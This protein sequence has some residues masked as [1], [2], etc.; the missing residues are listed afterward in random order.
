[1][2]GSSP[3]EYTPHS[4]TKRVVTLYAAVLVGLLGLMAYYAFTI[5]T[6]RNDW[7]ALATR[8][9]AWGGNAGSLPLLFVAY[10]CGSLLSMPGLVM[11]TILVTCLGP[12]EGML[13]AMTGTAASSCTVHLLASKLGRAVITELY[14]AR[15]SQVE[16]LLKGPPFLRVLQM[17]LLPVLP[18]HLVNAVAGIVGI[19]R[20]AF[21]GA[22]VAGLFPKMLVQ[23]FFVRTLLKGL[24]AP[25]SVVL[26]NAGVS[27]VLFIVVTLVGVKLER[28]IRSRDA[29]ASEL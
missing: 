5:G 16:G 20:Y 18:Y 10:Y 24:T 23:L 9:R 12:V 28:H 14:P 3:G 11:L 21:L 6:D 15:L 19:P 13:I 27:V 7:M 26:I 29:A 1:M 4:M 22:T 17:R 2:R 8:M 25:G